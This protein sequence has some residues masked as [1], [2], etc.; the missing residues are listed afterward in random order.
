MTFL[1]TILSLTHNLNLTSPIKQ[2][3]YNVSHTENWPQ[4]RKFNVDHC[5]TEQFGVEMKFSN[6]DSKR[7]HTKWSIY[8]LVLKWAILV[9]WTIE[10]CQIEREMPI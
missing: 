6:D 5:F 10:G 3:K 2:Q 7:L 8:F 1:Y 9:L 4:N